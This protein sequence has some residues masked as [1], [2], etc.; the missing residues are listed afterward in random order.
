MSG[1]PN[2][3]RA[4]FYQPILVQLI[5]I[6]TLIDFDHYIILMTFLMTI[7]QANC[8]YFPALVTLFSATA[9]QL[10]W[11]LDPMWWYPDISRGRCFIIFID[12]PLTATV[13]QPRPIPW[14][15]SLM[16]LEGGIL[17][18]S[19]ISHLQLL[20]ISRYRSHAVVP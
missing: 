12:F 11:I 3:S 5:I 10:I 18:L 6:L 15:G 8:A 4:V 20:Q 19:L 16:D 14:G 17:S 13:N 1:Y 7:F 2:G 9:N